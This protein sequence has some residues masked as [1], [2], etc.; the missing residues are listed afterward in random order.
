MILGGCA[1]LILAAVLRWLDL[2]KVA[3]DLVPAIAV[4]LLG[5]IAFI[6]LGLLLR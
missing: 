1:L 2:N 4:S 6:L 3:A 5:G